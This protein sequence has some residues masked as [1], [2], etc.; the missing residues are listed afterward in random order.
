MC[1]NQLADFESGRGIGG[2]KQQLSSRVAVHTPR[3][4][5]SSS[6][7][8][9]QELQ[10]ANKDDS[11]VIKDILQTFLDSVV[12]EKS[13]RGPNDEE[14][15]RALSRGSRY[16]AEDE[17]T[18][19]DILHMEPG[20]DY[21]VFSIDELMQSADEQHN[22]V[23]ETPWYVTEHSNRPRVMATHLLNN[24]DALIETVPKKCKDFNL[25][26][27]QRLAILS[28]TESLPQETFI[29]CTISRQ[30]M[31]EVSEMNHGPS[32]SR[33]QPFTETYSLGANTLPTWCVADF[34]TGS[35]KTVMAICAALRLMCNRDIWNS[36]VSNYPTLLR[37]RMRETHAGLIKLDT[38]EDS[39]LAKL[40]ILFVPGT[41]LDH[42]HQTCK[43]AIQGF[44]SI[45]GQHV[46]I[47]LWKGNSRDYSLQEA[48]QCGKPILWVKTL[49]S[50]SIRDTRATANIGYAVRIF[51]ELNA[52]MISRNEQP[53]SL[54][55]F[56]YITQATIEALTKATHGVPR[57]PFRLALGSNFSP[58]LH[59]DAAMARSNYTIVQSSLNH[60]CK[61]RMFAPP[62]F[63]RREVAN[64]AKWEMP[65]S[66]KC[67][68][69]HVRLGTLAAMETGTGIVEMTFAD[70]ALRIMGQ[71]VGH[72]YRERINDVFT[73]AE[74]FSSEQILSSLDQICS[75]IEVRSLSEN[76]AKQALLRL[77]DRLSSMLNGILP[78]CPISLAPIPKERVRIL[79]CCTCVLDSQ[80]L[81]QWKGGCP[82]CRAEIRSVGAARDPSEVVSISESKS[83]KR[84]STEAASKMPPKKRVKAAK[85]AKADSEDSEDSDKSD[86]S[87][88]SEDS[89]DSD[90]DGK[91]D[92]QAG[93][94]RE[95]GANQ[96]A[97]AGTLAFRERLRQIS[98]E[99]CVSV[100]G[101]MHI[102]RAQ[103][104]L[105]PSSRM[106]LCFAFEGHQQGNLARL[107]SRINR[108][109]PTA[110]VTD[111]ERCV[112]QPSRMDV[113]K[114][115]YDNARRFPEPQIFVINTIQ[116]SSSVQGM[117]LWA[118]DLT[119]VAS[120][121]SPATKRQAV[122][123]SL[124]MRPRPAEM[125]A[126][127]RF[128]GKNVVVLAYD[129]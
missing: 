105:N 74:V 109:F 101:V 9:K 41:V 117:D 129:A 121:C 64:G 67:Q 120:R 49:E 122:G 43:S 80:S 95:E 107:F 18:T 14:L 93:G 97:D 65:S 87:D 6:E 126:S 73:Q 31:V 110:S 34:C 89:E 70:L 127:E 83:E 27:Q 91:G 92:H 44:K 16:D 58:M 118:T 106:L 99:R 26:P 114:Q 37:E 15:G 53:E 84:P 46:D 63:L 124:R 57:H 54:P 47:L 88:D 38:I 71:H 61:M 4:Q 2:T 22:R 86:N 81:A 94:P 5:M 56:N 69:V 78:E 128:P 82:L 96:V 28:M 45:L 35:G 11:R 30:S 39:K 76:T 7:A 33:K 36:L 104:D 100:D 23:L 103:I 85:A 25:L 119:L 90:D 10:R 3:S 8:A 98:D 79:G 32:R 68:R 52:K 55:L 66:I 48:Y 24:I 72:V 62:E 123:R 19:S 75:E 12:D 77:K 50:E 108:E 1:Q 115:K 59:V 17:V 111:I 51:D 113:A 125:A 21:K 13:A 60:L 112:K 20:E 29:K 116:Q 40:A 42:W 102:L